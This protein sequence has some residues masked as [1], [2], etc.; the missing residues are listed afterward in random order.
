LQHTC[1]SYGVRDAR[2]GIWIA[3]V[4][5]RSAILPNEEK[6]K[7]N[8]A[9]GQDTKQAALEHGITLVFNRSGNNDWPVIIVLLNMTIFV[10]NIGRLNLPRI[11]G[12]DKTPTLGKGGEKYKA[13]RSLSQKGSSTV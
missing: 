4:T 3:G 9:S 10:N 2:A 12:P 7:E 8:N 1:A 5:L 13:L 6:A 11:D